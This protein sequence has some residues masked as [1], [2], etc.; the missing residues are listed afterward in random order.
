[1]SHD[2]IREADH[3]IREAEDRKPHA[4]RASYVSGCRCLPCRAANASYEAGRE[5]RK[6]EAVLVDA[7]D[8]R[9]HL[10]WL[11][12]RSVGHKQAA[13]LS[14]LSWVLLYG[15]RSGRRQRIRARTAASILAIQPIPADGAMVNS[16]HAR[17]LLRTLENEGFT[18]E[19]LAKRLKIRVTWMER[20]GLST[21]KGRSHMRQRLA[22]RIRRFHDFI[23]LE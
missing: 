15:I 22:A 13:K 10:Q 11:R 8:A 20:D 2:L 12:D 3:A 9:K 4:T 23:T 14:G 21:R 19:T 16:Y 5:A 1:M 18:A 7:A 6:A 17:H